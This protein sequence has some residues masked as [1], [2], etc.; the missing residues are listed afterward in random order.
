[1]AGCVTAQL[2]TVANCGAIFDVNCSG[3]K[4]LRETIKYIYVYVH[5]K[6][7]LRKDKSPCLINA[8]VKSGEKKWICNQLRAR[9][10]YRVEKL[11]GEFKLRTELIFKPQTELIAVQTVKSGLK[12]NKGLRLC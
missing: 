5:L 4:A 9:R 6:D 8:N 1:M 2:L 10:K 7:C 11:Y 3:L 12:K